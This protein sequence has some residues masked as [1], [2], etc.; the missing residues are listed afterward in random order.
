MMKYKLYLLF[1][2]K[3]NTKNSV[4]FKTSHKIVLNKTTLNPVRSL[5]LIN[6]FSYLNSCTSLMNT[7]VFYKNKFI[8]QATYFILFCKK[9]FKFFNMF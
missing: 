9:K 4:F 8:I 3:Y 7:S 1:F 2:F 6:A 5:I